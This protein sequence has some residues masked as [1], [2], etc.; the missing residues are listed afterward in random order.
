MG[1]SMVVMTGV[2]LA[3]SGWGP[4][5]LLNIP[6]VPRMASQRMVSPKCQQSQS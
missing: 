3:L 4:G 2:L 5:V 1:T 6:T